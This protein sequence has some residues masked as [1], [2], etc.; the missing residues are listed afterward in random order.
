MTGCT[1]NCAGAVDCA[2]ASAASTSDGRGTDAGRTSSAA[3]DVPVA[4][5]RPAA[6][7]TGSGAAAIAPRCLFRQRRPATNAA[8]AATMANTATPPTTPANAHVDRDTP[9][10]PSAAGAAPAV[11]RTAAGTLTTNELALN[12]TADGVMAQ[13]AATLDSRKGASSV[14]G[15]V[16]AISEANASTAVTL[17]LLRRSAKGCTVVLMDRPLSPPLA[18][19]SRA[20]TAPRYGPASMRRGGL[21]ALSGWSGPI[22]TMVPVESRTR[23]MSTCAASSRSICARE[24]RY[25]NAPA[26]CSR[27]SSHVT[28]RVAMR[29]SNAISTRGRLLGDCVADREAPGEGVAEVD[30]TTDGVRL[31]VTVLDRVALGEMDPVAECDTSCVN[32]G[33]GVLVPDAVCDADPEPDEVDESDGELVLLPVTMPDPVEETVELWEGDGDTEAVCDPEDDGDTVDET[34]EDPDEDCVLVPLADVVPDAVRDPE[35]DAVDVMDALWLP[36]DVLVPLADA[37]D[38]MDAV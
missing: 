25:A 14:C 18:C 2:D 5:L 35:E 22:N 9:G 33:V 27:K 11:A 24:R 15:G 10:T 1:C 4:W 21:A 3:S 8:T 16:A 37:V 29:I 13:L 7:T 30:G 38:V 17:T 34:D 6:G 12:D 31:L 20:D 36:L 19:R 28:A 32:D 26:G 23:E